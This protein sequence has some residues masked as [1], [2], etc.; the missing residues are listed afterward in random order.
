VSYETTV[1]YAP[2]EVTPEQ[3]EEYKQKYEAARQKAQLA[4]DRYHAAYY[5]YS[6]ALAELRKAESVYVWAQRGMVQEV[7]SENHP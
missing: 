7:T 3:L 4:D 6:D 2:G 1:R 5:V